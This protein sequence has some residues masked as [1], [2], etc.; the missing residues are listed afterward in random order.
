M[1]YIDVCIQNSTDDQKFTILPI[2]LESDI[3][4]EKVSL[5]SGNVFNIYQQN[6]LTNIL[7]VIPT[8][9]PITHGKQ[10]KKT[11]PSSSLVQSNSLIIYQVYCIFIIWTVNNRY[12]WCLTVFLS[13][14]ISH[15]LIVESWIITPA[16]A[17]FCWNC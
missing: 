17:K 1:L 14:S 2:T 12:F 9:V 16:C 6:F 3:Q 8:P 13:P 5:K 7:C 4:T 15:Y 11:T 10:Q